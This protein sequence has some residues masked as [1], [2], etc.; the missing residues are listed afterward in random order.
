M[1]AL[2]LLD[3][4]T[5]TI[6]SVIRVKDGVAVV[7]RGDERDAE[8]LMALT[9]T[10]GRTVLTPKDGDRWLRAAA[11]RLQSYISSSYVEDAVPA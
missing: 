1:G 9:V 5:G 10:E 11:A 7:E 8:R 2:Y 3:I 6:R 4:E